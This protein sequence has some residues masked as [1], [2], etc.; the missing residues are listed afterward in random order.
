MKRAYILFLIFMMIAAP[1]L[2]G[3][4]M[5]QGDVETASALITAKSGLLH[6]MIVTTDGTYAST[7]DI[8]DN[9]SEGSGTKLVPQFLVTSSATDRVQ[10]LSFSPPVRFYKGLYVTITSSGTDSYMVYWE[11]D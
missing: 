6:G 1:A 9:A 3:P 7:V 11:N 4:W 8:Y 5:K 10:A 2:A